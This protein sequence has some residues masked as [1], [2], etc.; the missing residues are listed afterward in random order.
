MTLTVLLVS[1][2]IPAFTLYTSCLPAKRL[3]TPVFYLRRGCF[4]NPPSK[5]KQNKTKPHPSE[6]LGAQ[7]HTDPLGEDFPALWPVSACCKRQLHSLP[8]VQFMVDW[9]KQLVPG[10]AALSL[11]LCSCTSES[12]TLMVVPV[13]SFACGDTLSPLPNVLQAGLPLL[14]V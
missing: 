13:G 5:T 10:S 9:D 6:T 1:I 11:S 7:T 12:D 2:K 3:S 4:K 8:A 14:P